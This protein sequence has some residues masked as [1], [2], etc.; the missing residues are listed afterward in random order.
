MT[1][2]NNRKQGEHAIFLFETTVDS[3]VGADLSFVGVVE[4][5][6]R[7]GA[8]VQPCDCRHLRILIHTCALKGRRGCGKGIW[9]IY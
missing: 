7:V 6:P 9:R 4:I 1:P 3:R 5:E 8:H 2:R